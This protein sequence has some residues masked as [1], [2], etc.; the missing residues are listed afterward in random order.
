LGFL[1][2]VVQQGRPEFVA[3]DFWH[4]AQPQLGTD[5]GDTFFV[6]KE[7]DFGAGAQ[8]GPTGDG[9]ALDDGEMTP[10]GFAGGE[11]G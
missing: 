9:V 8:K 2:E 11:D 6:T 1:K 5:F 10:K 4:M 7:D 3:G